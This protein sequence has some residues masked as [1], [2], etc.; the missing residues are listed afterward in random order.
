MKSTGNCLQT[1]SSLLK[2]FLESVLPDMLD[3]YLLKLQVILFVRFK[4]RHHRQNTPQHHPASSGIESSHQG[5][6]NQSLAT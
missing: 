2:T 5:C 4:Q 3:D 1:F 6:I